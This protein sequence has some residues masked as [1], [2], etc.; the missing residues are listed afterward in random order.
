M[1]VASSGECQSTEAASLR[2][3]RE[4]H[5][6]LCGGL[7]HPESS[8]SARM[9]L[10]S[11][12]LQQHAVDVAAEHEQ[13]SEEAT[14]AEQ[15]FVFSTAVSE[16]WDWPVVSEHEAVQRVEQCAVAGRLGWMMVDSFAHESEGEQLRARDCCRTA[17]VCVETSSSRPSQLHLQVSV[18]SQNL[19]AGESQGRLLQL[20]GVHEGASLLLRDQHNGGVCSGHSAAHW[21]DTEELLVDALRLHCA[22]RSSQHIC[23]ETEE[24]LGF[25]R[26]TEPAV[27]CQEEDAAAVETHIYDRSMR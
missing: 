4:E 27:A 20:V 14:S 6:S 11:G 16:A 5:L 8:E 12:D 24:S 15:R 25:P 7:I 17:V 18:C 10:P 23:S 2:V 9:H 1:Q 3:R 26:A 19:R 21:A 22:A 13:R